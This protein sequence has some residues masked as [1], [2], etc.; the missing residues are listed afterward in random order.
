MSALILPQCL[1]REEADGYIGS[2]ES[3]ENDRERSITVSTKRSMLALLA[4]QGKHRIC[5]GC[6][7]RR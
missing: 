3:G 6:P 1:K 5:A 7:P 4:P 2:G